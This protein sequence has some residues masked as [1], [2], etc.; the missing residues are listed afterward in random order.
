MSQNNFTSQLAPTRAI[1]KRMLLGAAFALLLILLFL[2]GGESS[3]EWGNYW[4]I[5]PLI[6]V[7][8]AGAIGGA[9]I[10]YIMKIIGGQGGWLKVAAVIFSCIAFVFILWIGTVLGLNGT[11]WN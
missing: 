7:P 2:S 8:I 6:V 1:T 3:P 5:K 11:Y 4:I 9:A 10:Y